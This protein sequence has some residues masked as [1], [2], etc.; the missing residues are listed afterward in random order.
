MLNVWVG[1]K[2]KR[3]YT[4]VNHLTHVK[5]HTMDANMNRYQPDWQQ[6]TSYRMHKRQRFW[7]IFFPVGLGVAAILTL[8]VLII[9]TAVRGDRAGD[10]S[11]WTDTSLILLI[12]PVLLF[13]V[14]VAVFL[15]V[16]IYLV[17]RVMKVLPPYA[18]IV[19]YYSKLIANKTRGL[20]DKLVEPMIATQSVKARVRAFFSALSGCLS[21]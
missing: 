2:L 17:G 5:I 1:I 11:I 19:Q 4:L 21:K 8:A 6:S 15:F 3:G 20:L 14:G 7:Q 13:A 9:L 12:L 16:L 18:A 10:I